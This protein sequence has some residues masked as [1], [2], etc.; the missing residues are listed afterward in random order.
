MIN[1]CGYNHCEYKG[2]CKTIVG[3]RWQGSENNLKEYIL[4]ITLPHDVDVLELGCG[5]G[6]LSEE[7]RKKNRVVSVDIYANYKKANIR[8]LKKQF[9][10]NTK[11]D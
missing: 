10:I 6:E 8:D 2:E 9:N 11:F 4:N 5:L 1:N 7:L 3:K